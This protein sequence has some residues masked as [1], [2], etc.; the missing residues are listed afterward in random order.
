VTLALLAAFAG[1][2]VQA[3]TG[4]GFAL[5]LAPA[6]LA[7][8]APEAALPA[9]GALGLLLSLLV[10]AERPPVRWRPLVPVLLAA[11]PGALLGA[12]VLR[13]APAD[14]LRCA[15]GVA[16]LGAVALRARG[17]PPR[18]RAPAPAVGLAVG[19]LT[20]SIGVNGPP[21]ALHLRDLAPAELRGTLAAAYL[22]LGVVG[23][24]ALAP[25]ALD[26]AED[27]RPGVAAAAAGA[28]VAG[29]ALGRLVFTRLDARRFEGALLVV[30][31]ATGVAAI[32]GALA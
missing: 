16:V 9:L 13:A 26:A 27:L 23:L 19:A 10:L 20:T 8:L 28:V 32:A 4:I 5:V 12:V 24:A 22:V 18:L 14:A 15:V 2:L 29:H 11:A 6:L 30:L 3:A 7:V 1:A 31:A 21:L 17:R 25:L